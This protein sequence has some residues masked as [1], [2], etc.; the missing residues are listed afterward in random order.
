MKI[1]KILKSKLVILALLF[2]VGCTQ[3]NQQTT[4]ILPTFIN[5]NVAT[6]TTTN[7]VQIEPTGTTE[8]VLSVAQVVIVEATTE[9]QNTLLIQPTFE[10]EPTA[11]QI[12]ATVEEVLPLEVAITEVSTAQPTA[13]S[14]TV[15]SATLDYMYPGMKSLEIY[16]DGSVEMVIPSLSESTK[17]PCDMNPV[18]YGL[19]NGMDKLYDLAET[20]DGKI[21]MYVAAPICAV[22]MPMPYADWRMS[23]LAAAELPDEGTYTDIVMYGYNVAHIASLLGVSV[24]IPSDARIF[25]L[26]DDLWSMKFLLLSNMCSDNDGRPVLQSSGIQQLLDFLKSKVQ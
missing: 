2:S 23:Q 6:Q 14:T 9:S 13:T 18:E 12:P 3:T 8:T 24:D 17:P 4:L 5:T 21:C 20:R 16:A 25:I 19:A 1:K 26:E 22:D 10:S 11:I 15:P 7:V